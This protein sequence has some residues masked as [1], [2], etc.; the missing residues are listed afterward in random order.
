MVLPEMDKIWLMKFRRLFSAMLLAFFLVM[1]ASAQ[2]PKKKGAGTEP[3]MSASKAPALMD[4]NSASIDQL[5]TLPGIGDAY[6][7]KIF[8]NRPYVNKAQLVSKK[9]IPQATYDKIK[10]LIIAKQGK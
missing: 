6:S 7:K 10:S 5:K 9:I 8:D 2:A 4:I 3:K 1:T